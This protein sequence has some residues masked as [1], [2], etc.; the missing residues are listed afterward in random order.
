MD[1]KALIKKYNVPAP[2]YTSY[3]TVPFWEEDAPSVEQWLEAVRKTFVATNSDKGI[4]VYVHLPFC[5]NL[6]TYCGCNKRI[7]KNHRVEE[8]YLEAVLKEWKFYLENLPEKPVLR[9]IHVGG[10]TPTF[11]SPENLKHLFGQIFETVVVPEE[12]DYS[13]EGHPNNTTEEHLKVLAEIGFNRVSY[14]VQDF[15]LKVQTTINRIQPYKHVVSAT[16]YARKHGYNSVNFDLVYGLP[17]Q[18]VEIIQDTLAKIKDLKPDRIAFYSYAHVP[19]TAKGQRAYDE[20]DLPTDAEKRALYEAGKQGLLA[21]GYHDIGM[22]H[23]ALEGDSLY[24]AFKE[25]RLHRNFMGYTTNQTDLMIGLGCS[26][27]SDAWTAFA[28]TEKKVEDYQKAVEENGVGLI[29]GHFLTEEDLV[30]REAI[31][32]LICHNALDLSPAIKATLDEGCMEQLD[33]FEAEGI[34]TLKDDR[35]EMTVP[36]IAFIRNVCMV[37]D[38]RLRARKI[39]ADQPIFSK[40]I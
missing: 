14:G 36:G 30:I 17:F 2:R 31:L 9:E 25:N 24:Q 5:E 11:F 21:M 1:H 32:E 22:D 39:A 20:N 15:D 10:G 13:F 7:T 3:P 33:T 38:T 29:K 16:Q 8:P 18:T 40:S 6:C 12:K 26:S 28:Q 19:W 27:I 34:L 35:L 4:S 23:F 37:F